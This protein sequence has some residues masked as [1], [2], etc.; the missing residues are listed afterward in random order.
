MA[1]FASQLEKQRRRRVERGQTDDEQ[2]WDRDCGKGRKFLLSQPLKKLGFKFDSINAVLGLNH[3]L[4][5]E[6]MDKMEEKI[7][8]VFRVSDS[9]L[10]SN[11]SR[12]QL[13]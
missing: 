2:D 13:E 9:A 10:N 3:F 8:E 11:P 4:S 6:V 12:L 7:L 1:E 5:Q